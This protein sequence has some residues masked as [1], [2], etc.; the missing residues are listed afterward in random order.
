MEWFKL[1]LLDEDDLNEQHPDSLQLK[2]ARTLLQRAGK[3]AVSAVADYLRMLWAHTLNDIE[4]DLGEIAV[5]GLPFRVVLT[6]PA[7]W[8]TR[9]VS[10]MRRAAKEAGILKERLAGETTVH[11][12]SEPEAAAIAT[13]EDLKV[14]PNFRE[15]DTFVVCDAGG[16]TVDLISY[17]VLQTDPLQLGECVEGSGQLCGAVFLDQD[18]E[19]LMKQ[20]VGS[21]WDVPDDVIKRIVDEQ[22]ENG[23]KRGFEGR[24]RKWKITLPIEYVDRG[25]PRYITLN[26]YAVPVEVKYNADVSFSGHVSKIF[27]NVIS[28]V[29]S[30]VNDQIE[31]VE[32]QESQD[33]RL[34]KVIIDIYSASL[35]Y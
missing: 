29:R 18:F 7:V 26:R 17:K 4:K 5:E 2:R 27:E 15:G 23:I 20:L 6:V 22:W 21:A 34:P 14:R 11:F 8:T 12:V 16:G 3:T 19:G 30:L 24:E 31:A 32:S 13:F 35:S 1:L 9:A 33:P 10:R 28:K 25:A